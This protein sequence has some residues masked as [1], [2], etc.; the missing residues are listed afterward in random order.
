MAN[1]DINQ[2]RHQFSLS[3]TWQAQ[4]VPGVS[5]MSRE[6]D[7]TRQLMVDEGQ[8]EP[9]AGEGHSPLEPHSQIALR[10]HSVIPVGLV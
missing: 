3:Q 2:F 4:A 1:S 10:H 7:L 5:R 8:A 9:G 6:R